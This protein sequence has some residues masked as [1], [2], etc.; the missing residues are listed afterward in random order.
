MSNK[1]MCELLT[2]INFKEAEK[3]YEEEKDERI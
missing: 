1:T 2:M 3:M